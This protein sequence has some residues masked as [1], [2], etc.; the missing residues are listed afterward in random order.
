M[1]IT[2]FLARDIAPEVK[3]AGNYTAI[4][5]IETLSHS[6]SKE[7]AD[8]T[9]FDSNGHAEHVVVQRGDEW[10][11]EGFWLQD[12]STGATDPGQAEL[13]EAAREIGLTATR[14]VR[15]T[16]PS[17]YGVRFTCSVEVTG[18]DGGHN[19]LA[20][21]SAVLEVTGEPHYFGPS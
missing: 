18:P 21:F 9:D 13:V 2:K 8:S 4:G 3:I 14:E 16:T 17:G 11:L 19:D 1:A 5:G 6:P 15:L 12:V 20:A 7:T 10:T